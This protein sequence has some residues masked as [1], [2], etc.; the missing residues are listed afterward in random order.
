VV[1]VAG[2]VVDA[3]L[4]AGPEGHYQSFTAVA[5]RRPIGWICYG[6]T[7]C[8]AGTFDIYWIAVAP[9]RQRHGI[10]R[11][12]LAFAERLMAAR[13]G[14]LAV[15]ETAGRDAYAPTRAFY[16]RCGYEAAARLPDFYDEGDDKIVLVKRL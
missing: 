3:A 7:P 16:A 15:V 12:L 2:E 9:E 6:P 5:G 10:G 11:L 8:T 1:A 4:G 13:G 14:R